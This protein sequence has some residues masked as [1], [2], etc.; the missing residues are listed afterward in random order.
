M[1]IK[2]IEPHPAGLRLSLVPEVHG[3]EPDRKEHRH[4]NDGE[5]VVRG[6]YDPNLRNGQSAVDPS[7]TDEKGQSMNSMITVVTS[8][9]MS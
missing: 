9:V 3:D 6:A 2:K 7:K 8:G 5:E 4:E 1:V